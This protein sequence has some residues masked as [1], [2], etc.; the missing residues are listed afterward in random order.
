MT[1]RYLLTITLM[2]A[3]SACATATQVASETW[4]GGIGQIQGDR[5]HWAHFIAT[6]TFSENGLTGEGE[7]TAGE[8]SYRGMCV[9]LSGT[10]DGERLTLSVRYDGQ[11]LAC[12][13]TMTGE[14]AVATC[15]S[16]TDE[17]DF[18]IVRAEVPT[19]E[20]IDRITGAYA[21]A[22]D[23]RFQIARTS[24]SSPFMI[25]LK[26]G[27]FRRLFS[28]GNNTWV[29]GPLVLVGA[30]EQWRIRFESAGDGGAS[31][32]WISKDGEPE[33]HAERTAKP[34]REEFT[35]ETQD[36][37]EIRG[38]LTLPEGA[39][40][41]PAIVWVHGSG[42][43]TRNSATF[44][45]DYFA[46]LGFAM[47]A[48]D[49]RSVGESGG[50]YRLPDGGRDNIPHMQRR[51]KD[52][53]SAVRALKQDPRIIPDRIGLTGI[54]QA[55]WIM[56]VVA[57]AG[58]NAFTITL[59]GGATQ[60]SREGLFSRLAGE[61]RSDAGLPSVEKIL[62]EVRALNS[63]DYDWSRDFRNQTSPGLW[64]YGLKDRSNP[65]LLCIEMIE[66]IAAEYGKDFTVA[67]FPNGSHGLFESRVSGPSE[68]N[69]VSQYVPGLFSTIEG[70]LSDQGFLSS[71]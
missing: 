3:A 69:V 33:R 8:S 60:I 20:D 43:V 5:P 64:L 32:L 48:V 56:P 53:L 24:N 4:S 12:D 36:G 29:A 1:L 40:P 14:E 2:L 70:W 6:L 50:D 51:A 71:L 11:E 27:E 65:S 45:P 18:R 67:Q 55:G 57:S 31:S 38:S 16:G 68:R 63:R 25:D 61:T 26:S 17:M 52:V 19:D 44:W 62:P 21:L 22:P 42:P 15:G 49:K 10:V 23:H 37:L 58:E 7:F 13:G 28:K 34:R 47:L 39:G 54:S 41:H 66:G 9:D 46:G 30:P 59:S 35:F